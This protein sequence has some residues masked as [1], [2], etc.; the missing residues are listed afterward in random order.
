MIKSALV[1]ALLFVVFKT[2]TI[3]EQPRRILGPTAA[4][5]TENTVQ[6]E[7]TDPAKILVDDYSAIVEKDIFGTGESSHGQDEVASGGGPASE[8]PSAERELGLAL[9][10]TVSGSPTVAR[11]VVEQTESGTIGVHRTGDT[12]AGAIVVS[13]GK[14]TVILNYNGRRLALTRNL[15]RLTSNKGGVREA[16]PQQMEQD[17]SVASG[18]LP[19]RQVPLDDRA[20]TGP[21]ETL[22]SR[23]VIE[24]YAVNGRTAGL[25][26][27]GLKDI[28][29][30]KNLG[31]KEG[32]V[33]TVVNRQQLTSKQKAFQI[34]KK[35]RGQPTVSMELLRD[36]KTK[37][38]SF[39]LR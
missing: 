26:I 35:A 16:A 30:A 28:P 5:G 7:Q 11:A 14:E 27:T 33:I 23:A 8:A 18:N 2:V 4:V 20:G 13:I 12:V 10:G 37:K 36:N 24:P 39:A 6:L 29:Q 3:S 17:S 15:S 34:L 1:L 32:D 38:I 25:R 21:V 22:L 19:V 31:L 9:L